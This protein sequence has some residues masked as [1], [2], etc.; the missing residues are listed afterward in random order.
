LPE[1]LIKSINLLNKSIGHSINPQLYWAKHTA[2]VH[3]VTNNR[4]NTPYTIDGEYGR[5]TL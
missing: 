3:K 1:F 2:P 4:Y 5:K